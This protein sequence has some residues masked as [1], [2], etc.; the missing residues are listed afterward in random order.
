MLLAHL[1][2]T[3]RLSW[4]LL[5]GMEQVAAP[6]CTWR[7]I[8]P[9]CSLENGANACKAPRVLIN[10]EAKDSVSTALLREASS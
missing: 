2:H 6:F 3:P 4:A 1:V 10:T 7:N 9:P 5:L 8:N